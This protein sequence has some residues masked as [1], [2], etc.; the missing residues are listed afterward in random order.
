MTIRHRLG[1]APRK[2]GS[3]RFAVWAPHAARVEL[4]L[5]DP[6]DRAV[7]MDRQADAYFTAEV[8]AL[9]PDARYRYR[10]H[11]AD[12][13]MRDRPDPASRRQPDGVHGPSQ[14]VPA[15]FA[16][17]DGSWCGLPLAHYV[18]YE[19]HVGTFSREGTFGGVIRHL[20]ALVDLGVT[21]VELMPVAQFPGSRNWGYDGVYPFAVQNSYGG[22]E[23]LKRLVNACHRRGLAV[24]L[25]VVYN[26]LGPEGNYLR[27]FG[28]YFTDVYRTPWGE[29]LNFDGPHSDH[30]RRYFIENALQW[31]DEF[32]I[33]ALRLD[34]VHAILDGSARPFLEGL[35]RAVHRRARALNRRIHLIAESALND[36]RVIRPRELGGFALDAQWNDDF[37]HSLHTALTGERSGYYRDYDGIADL[38]RA[39]REG[40]VYTGQY[41]PFRQRAHGN[42]SRNVP[43]RQF[44]VFAQN[45]DQVGNRL[46]GER[47]A[48]QV[49]F[50]KQ[51]LAAAAVL[52]SPFIPLIFM[53]EE[54]GE[55]APF[56]YFV[57]HGDPALVRAVQEGRQRE[58]AAFDWPGEP[59]DPQDPTTFGLSMLNRTLR[60]DERGHT[61]LA[62]YRTLL[63]LRREIP[64]LAHL[65]KKAMTVACDHRQSLLLVT[66]RL[67]D[68]ASF[69]MLTFSDHPGP[70]HIQPPP[71]CWRKRIDSA[72]RRW[73]GPGSG[74]DD[75]LVT[76]GATTLDAGAHSAV[77]FS[78][79]PCRPES[80]AE[81]S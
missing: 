28:P 57:N 16:W 10:L 44:V 65:S 32:R 29:A 25:D 11:L 5:T 21:A 7:P 42:S 66:R 30:V 37:H 17:S 40:Y 61:L 39:W 48:A 13:E 33:D 12:G 6:G 51:K 49:D 74:I 3:C 56:L 53:G 59:P 41:S 72:D 19:L 81:G 46:G 60:D 14:A 50:E 27:D 8:A 69:L 18:I 23:G 52:L 67:G 58:F 54:Y 77:V 15:D 63:A 80:R 9:P 38:A 73:L 26:H 1:A 64:E 75:T 20:D 35:G 76:D 24:V 4:L 31:V 36:T 70:V 45:H 68:R 2:D 34:A 79:M 78:R 55:T 71:G 22:P 43:A 62:F 47:L